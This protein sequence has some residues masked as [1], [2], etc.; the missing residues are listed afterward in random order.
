MVSSTRILVLGAGELGLSILTALASLDPKP[1]LSVLLRPE[2]LSSSD[3]KLAIL[4]D[5]SI[6]AIPADLSAIPHAELTSLFKP[7]HTIIAANGAS[8]SDSILKVAECVL[9]AG[10]PRFFPWQFGVDYDIVGLGSPARIWDTQYRVRQLL[11]D[12]PPPARTEWVIV[13][14]GL[15]MSML[16]MP[17][18]GIVDL[19]HETVR[20][21]NSWETQ[22]TTTDVSD[23]GR[24]IAGILDA[25]PPVRNEIVY[26]A[27]S[28]VTYSELAQILDDVLGRKLRRECWSSEF[29]MQE[30]KRLGGEADDVVRYRSAFA[31]P[32]GVAWPVDDTWNLKRGLD[33]VGVEEYSRKHLLNGAD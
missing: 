25:E 23:I 19:P 9:S 24:C 15:F 13:S 2:T 6:T 7:F 21:L 31:R 10:V 29:L 17:A 5:L 8:S 32:T 4:R 11:R 26:L 1:V 14:T 30:L 22:I 33:M 16:F 18:F 27:G 12:Q 28:T 3:P 20:A